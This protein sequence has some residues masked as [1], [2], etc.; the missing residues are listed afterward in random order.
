M[1]GGPFFLLI[2]I[3]EILAIIDIRK[4]RLHKV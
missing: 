3:V 1:T 4:N 2:I